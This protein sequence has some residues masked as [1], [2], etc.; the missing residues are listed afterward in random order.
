MA[1]PVHPKLGM[2]NVVDR[3]RI[4]R[5]GNVIDLVGIVPDESRQ[6]FHIFCGSRH[7]QS[8]FRV[9]EIILGINNQQGAGCRLGHT[10][11]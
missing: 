2:R 5:D 10:K 9:T 1:L 4:E 11:E 3:V 7:V 8:A 6:P